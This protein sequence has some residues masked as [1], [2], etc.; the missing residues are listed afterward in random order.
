MINDRHDWLL[1]QVEEFGE[2]VRAIAAKAAGVE[3]EG[4]IE[5][6]ENEIDSLLERH[7]DHPRVRVVD[8]RTAA[9]ILRP[10][11]RIRSYAAALTTKADLF[12]RRGELGRAGD[13]I[14]RALELHLEAS[15]L[16]EHPER[17]DRAAIVSLIDR[18][19]PPPLAPR[20]RQLLVALASTE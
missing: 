10:P 20:Y 18:D 14:R 11:D 9:R 4:D 15:A 3:D 19:P 16:E 13:L 8:A 1:V 2:A 17:I 6:A 5:Q 12:E 7:F